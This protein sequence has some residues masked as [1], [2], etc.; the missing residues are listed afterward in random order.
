MAQAVTLAGHGAHALA[1]Y[2]GIINKARLTHVL[3]AGMRY[4]P[5]CLAGEFNDGAADEIAQLKN[6]GIPQGVTVYADME[7]LR[8][9][10]TPPLEMIAKLDTWSSDILAAGWLPGLYVGSPQPLTSEELWK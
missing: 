4:V 6:L 3:N 1:G 9:F 2:L 7:G 10:G 5:V 8:A